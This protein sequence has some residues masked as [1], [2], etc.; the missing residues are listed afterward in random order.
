MIL[1]ILYKSLLAYLYLQRIVFRFALRARNLSQ[2]YVVSAI[3]RRCV[4]LTTHTIIKLSKVRAFK[5][6]M[7]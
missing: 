4:T 6:N 3:L 5:E 7:A 1:H 2:V